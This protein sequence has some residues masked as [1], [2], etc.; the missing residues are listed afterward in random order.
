[1]S[2]GISRVSNGVSKRGRRISL[3]S[4]SVVPT[5]CQKVWKI[6]KIQRRYAASQTTQLEIN[7]P[8]TT[9]ELWSPTPIRR[10]DAE[11]GRFISKDPILFNGGL[12]LYGYAMNDPVNFIDVT[13]KNPLAIAAVIGG[14][15]AAGAAGSFLGTLAATGSFVQAR[16]AIVPGAIAGAAAMVGPIAAVGLGG[17][18]ALGTWLGLG[19]DLSITAA[20]A[21]GSIPDGNERDFGVGLGAIFKRKTPNQ[22]E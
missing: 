3:R 9:N 8:P 13:G 16:S 7:K 11:V 5:S 2:V 4:R 10:Y 22:C 12:N 15:A 14:G 6:R 18:V 17:S 20:N 1:M 19:A 21:F